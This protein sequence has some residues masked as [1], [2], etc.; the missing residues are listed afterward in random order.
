M[1]ISEMVAYLAHWILKL[2]KLTP[3]A[4][5]GLTNVARFWPALLLRELDPAVESLLDELRAV[6]GTEMSS[7]GKTLL[8]KRECE[9]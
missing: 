4:W 8:T 9:G 1:T 3:S 6:A 7:P 2:R 5:R